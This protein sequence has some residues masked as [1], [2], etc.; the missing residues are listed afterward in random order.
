M[1]DAVGRMIQGASLRFL[2]AKSGQ[3]AESTNDEMAKMRC[4]IEYSPTPSG[5]G[6]MVRPNV[7]MAAT[8]KATRPGIASVRP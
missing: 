4:M 3:P 8:N 2:I 7:Q 1:I 5:V 6:N